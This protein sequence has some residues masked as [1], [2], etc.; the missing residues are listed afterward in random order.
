MEF[1]V[2]AVGDGLPAGGEDLLNGVGD[3]EFVGCTV[4]ESVDAG[5]EGFRGTDGVGGVGGSSVNVDG[6]GFRGNGEE[7]GE[8]GK[9]A[10]WLHVC[11]A[12]CLKRFNKCRM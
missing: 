4:R 3:V 2:L 5:A 1:G 11:L 8:K 10:G 12:P 6:L 9:E 7:K